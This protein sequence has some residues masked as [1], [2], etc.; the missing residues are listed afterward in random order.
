MK[1]EWYD[2]WVASPRRSLL[3]WAF[4]ALIGFREGEVRGGGFMLVSKTFAYLM[5]YHYPPRRTRLGFR[6]SCIEIYVTLNLN[7]VSGF[8]SRSFRV[9]LRCRC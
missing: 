1:E 3:G 4:V 5:F 7:K 6:E 9:F 8:I 2:S